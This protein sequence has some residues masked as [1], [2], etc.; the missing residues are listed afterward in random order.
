MFNYKMFILFILIF[1]SCSKEDDNT[2]DNSLIKCDCG[3]I[4][5]TGVS[6]PATDN[7][8]SYN[9]FERTNECSGEK[10]TLYLYMVGSF[11]FEIGDYICNLKPIHY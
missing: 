2:P 7:T 1:S 3:F 5:D 9:W 4:T 10:D 8:P 11:G 6:I